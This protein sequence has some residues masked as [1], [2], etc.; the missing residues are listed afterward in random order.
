MMFSPATPRLGEG[1]V[2]KIMLG[3]LELRIY[4]GGF[5]NLRNGIKMSND[6]GPH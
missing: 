6:W 2:V 3:S 5:S 1:Q 4:L